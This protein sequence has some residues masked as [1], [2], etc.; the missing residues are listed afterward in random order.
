MSPA[1]HRLLDIFRQYLMTPGRMLCLNSQ[2]L[3]SYRVAIVKLI[4]NDLLTK[5][6]YKGGYSLTEAG[7]EMMKDMA[8]PSVQQT[9]SSTKTPQLPKSTD[10]L[11]RKHK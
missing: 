10:R 11:V 7:Y 5:E 4:E 6:S 3:Q 9:P 1:E 2:Q 8:K